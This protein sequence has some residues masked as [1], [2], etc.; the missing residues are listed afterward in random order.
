[1]TTVTSDPTSAPDLSEHADQQQSLLCRLPRELR[2]QIYEYYSYDEEGLE[3]DYTSKTLQ[4]ASGKE[5]NLPREHHHV[6]SLLSGKR[7]GQLSWITLSVSPI[8]ASIA[9]GPV[10]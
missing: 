6:H 4:Y 10:D 8:R 2:D 5:L 9:L 7:R 3:Y 1:M